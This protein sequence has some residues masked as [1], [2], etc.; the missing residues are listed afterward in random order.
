MTDL[1][2]VKEKKKKTISFVP[3]KV[4]SNL[5][6]DLISNLNKKKRASR[7]QS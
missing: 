4:G 5:V 7:A 3:L 6:G 1:N 2:S